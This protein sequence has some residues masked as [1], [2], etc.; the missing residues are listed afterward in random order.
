MTPRSPS[1]RATRTILTIGATIFLAPVVFLIPPHVE[2][3]VMT[4]V[5]GVYWA[6]KNWTAEYVVATFSGIC[7]RCYAAISIKPGT[8][9]RLPH[10]VV[11]YSCH[12]HPLLETGSAPP[13]DEANRVDN[14]EPDRPVGERRP[15]R[16]WSPAGS[17]W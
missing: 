8:T 6:R 9:L 3:V 7:P 5:T 17:D 1:Q 12:E 15:F 2:W 4:I 14:T 16:I 10:S 11:C 13:V